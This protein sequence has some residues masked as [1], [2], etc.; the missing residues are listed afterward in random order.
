MIVNKT[1]ASGTNG[2]A[3]GERIQVVMAYESVDGDSESSKKTVR[4]TR[5]VDRGCS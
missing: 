5:W 2:L 3:L 4:R 1:G